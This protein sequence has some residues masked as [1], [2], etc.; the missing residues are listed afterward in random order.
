MGLNQSW[1]SRIHQTGGQMF[2]TNV[3][4]LGYGYPFIKHKLSKPA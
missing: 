3:L 2:F 1:V 4:P